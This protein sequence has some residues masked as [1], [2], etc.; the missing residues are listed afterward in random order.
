MTSATDLVVA[1]WRGERRPPDGRWQRIAR[2]VS[3]GNVA[4]LRAALRAGFV[5]VG[6]VQ[7]HRP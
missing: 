7:L 2:V 4:S 1:A 3:P 5:P 6:S